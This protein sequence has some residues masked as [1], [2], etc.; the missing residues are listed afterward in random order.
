MGVTDRHDMTLA[1]KAVLNPETTNHYP[2][3]GGPVVARYYH[4]PGRQWE[5]PLPPILKNL[6]CRGSN[7]RPPA[8]EADTITTWPPRRSMFISG[9]LYI[10]SK[11]TL[12]NMVTLCNYL[13]FQASIQ[14]NLTR[15]L[16]VLKDPNERQTC[17]WIRMRVT[18]MW[19]N[20]LKAI[21]SLAKKE[22]MQR[23]RRRQVL[24]PGLCVSELC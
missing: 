14:T 1:V 11:Q 2:D 21:Y 6:V 13:K 10:L 4:N 22:D 9:V 24:Y 18:R 16:N 20:W 15:L 7:P 19:P 12:F 5:K 3:T 23:R 8:H 17:A